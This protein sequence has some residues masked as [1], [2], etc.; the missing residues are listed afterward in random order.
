MYQQWLKRVCNVTKT[1][2][3]VC[4]QYILSTNHRVNYVYVRV[5][6]PMFLVNLLSDTTPTL[7]SLNST[8]FSMY[9]V[10]DAVDTTEGRAIVHKVYADGDLALSFPDYTFPDELFTMSPADVS[11]STKRCRPSRTPSKSV[12]PENARP[13]KRQRYSD[14]NPVLVPTTTYTKDHFPVVSKTEQNTVFVAYL[15]TLGL[16]MKQL[17]VLVL[18]T[19]VLRTTHMLLAA[20]LMPSHIYIPQPNGVEAARMLEAYPTLR[21]FAG[22]K[23][24][25]LIWKLADRGVRFHGAMMDYCGAP[26]TIG[27]KN[28]PVDDMDNLLRYNLL[29]DQA[30]LTQTVCARSCRKVTQK[31]EGFKHLVTTIQKCARRDGRRMRKAQGITYTDPGSQTMCHFRCILSK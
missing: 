14:R 29:A 25:D 7:S 19:S 24:G 16:P 27:R 8:Y 12:V 10:G 20:G 5:H 26:G 17:Y 28:T 3:Q 21:V 4:R 23:A 1:V 11:R 30:V 18:D 2:V 9:Q 6:N 31:F 22:L 15:R 13:T